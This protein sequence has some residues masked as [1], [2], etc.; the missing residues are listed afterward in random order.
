G[1]PA[2]PAITIGAQ[3]FGESAILAEIY[4]QALEA[5]GY[6]ARIQTLGGFRPLEIEAFRSNTINFA[7]EYA[8]SM[9]EFLNENA[10]EANADPID[11][12]TKLNERL[13]D[14]GLEALTPTDAVDT[15]AFV[16]TGET[17]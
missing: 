2:G 3:D 15:N 10:G 12:V 7:P 14:L 8:A 5:G 11:T 17:A 16:V 13:R 4:R 6:T 9:L 1:V